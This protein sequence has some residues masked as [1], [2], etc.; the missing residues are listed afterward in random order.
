VLLSHKQT[1]GV[2]GYVLPYTYRGH[3]VTAIFHQTGLRS[4][5]NFDGN[6]CDTVL[7]D[8]GFIDEKCNDMAKKKKVEK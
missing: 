8:L 6:C 1:I 5:A 2:T 4:L 7:V 3:L